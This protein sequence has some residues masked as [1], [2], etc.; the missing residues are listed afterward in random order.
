M[1]RTNLGDKVSHSWDGHWPPQPGDKVR[2]W[3]P[4]DQRG[5]TVA[6]VAND[7][8]SKGDIKVAPE[9]KI[10]VRFKGEDGEFVMQTLTVRDAMPTTVK[11]KDIESTA[12]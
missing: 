10:R 9:N 1:A 3:N 7:S 5:K 8:K 11:I 12:A 2:L 6:V 4:K